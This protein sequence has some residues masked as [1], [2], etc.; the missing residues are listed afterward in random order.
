MP[1]DQGL[2]FVRLFPEASEMTAMLRHV[3]QTQEDF[4]TI[5]LPQAG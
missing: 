2:T 5:G 3:V 4:T 1:S